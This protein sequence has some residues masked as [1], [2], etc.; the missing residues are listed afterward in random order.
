MIQKL[1]SENE[2]TISD[3]Q[4]QQF[5]KYFNLLIE[6]NQRINLTSITDYEEVIWKHFI[7]SALLTKSSLYKDRE[8]KSVLDLG[9][10]AG[11]PGIVLAIL[12]PEKHFVLIDSLQK[13]IDF[14]SYVIQKLRL[15]N[16][17]VFHGRAEDY[18]RKENFRNQFD[19]VV[20]R[21]VAELPLLLEYCI[22]FV[23]ENGY[24]VSYKSKRYREE[25]EI[26]EYA[27]S[28]LTSKLQKVESYYLKD[29]DE[30]VLLIIQ[31]LSITNDK[32]PRRA[33]KP[34]KKPLIKESF[35]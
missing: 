32:Y 28:E 2:I 14:L 20:S 10:G 19:F 26:S 8:R 7:D 4:E 34:K 27:F 17:Q 1:F 24:F 6:W 15:D 12:T 35:T 9:T 23:K 22:P 3:K 25:I 18:G 16:V 21:A 29:G 13:R 33:G 11:F 30:R 5:Q 31:N